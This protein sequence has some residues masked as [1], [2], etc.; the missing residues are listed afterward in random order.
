MNDVPVAVGG[1][2]RRCRDLPQWIADQTASRLWILTVVA[3]L[4]GPTTAATDRDGAPPPDLGTRHSGTDWPDFL[5]P[6]RNG[7]SAETGLIATWPDT[8]PR[9]VWQVPL[10]TSYSAPSVSRGR[11]FHFDRHGNVDRVTCRESETGRELWSREHATSYEDILGYNNGPRCTPVVDGDRVYTMS[12][13]GI[14]QC[15]AVVDGSVRWQLDTMNEFGVAQNF[16]GVGSTPV[17][18]DDLLIANVGG[19]PPGGPDNVYSGPVHG[20]GTGAVAFDKYSGKVRW[21]VSDELAS[22]AS[23][24]VATVS[25][26]TRCFLFARGGLLAVDSN[27]GKV[28][29]HFPWRA[30]K[31]ESVNAASP[32]VVDD[33]VFISESYGRGSALLRV[34]EGSY[35]EIWTDRE[36]GRDKSLELHWNTPIHHEGFLYGSSGQHGGPAELRCIEWQTGRVRWRQAGLA[37]VSLIHADGKL[38][39]LSEDGTLRLLKA[40]PDK[41]D[42]I[43]RWIP[44]GDDGR[45]L[46]KEPAW[47]APV[48]AHKLL[49]VRGRDRLICVE[50]DA[51]R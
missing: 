45:P 49:Y 20:N 31:L 4:S 26:T 11:L 41:Y 33:T 25:G 10:G 12:A 48:L 23:P 51:T 37:R 5:G 13:E 27:Q 35:D 21:Q 50:F 32:V 36:R 24:V 39:C 34:A 38:I 22:Y 18:V 30:A 2:R 6:D 7:K 16:F 14:L 29:F 47:V 15:L 19:S 43:A 9:M 42:E 3:S 17:V 8:G 28:A 44:R 1:R 40:T 46:L